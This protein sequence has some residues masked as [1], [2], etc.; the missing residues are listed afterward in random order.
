LRSKYGKSSAANERDKGA[1]Q[2]A[3]RVGA[4]V[5]R[6]WGGEKGELVGASVFYPLLLVHD[7][8]DA[9]RAEIDGVIAEFGGDCRRAIRALLHD[10]T[11]LAL[12]SAAAVSKGFVRGRLMPFQIGEP[13]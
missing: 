12:D 13:S 5:R 8:A 1:A 3:R 6:E 9:T 10:L 2:R 7:I 4:I 11:Q